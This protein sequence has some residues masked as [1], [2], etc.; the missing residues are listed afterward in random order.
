MTP[1]EQDRS[2]R[3]IGRSDPGG[4]RASDIEQRRGA[5]TG[6]MTRVRNDR[7]NGP[8]SHWPD[9]LRWR[10]GPMAHDR[11]KYTDPTAR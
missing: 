10:N 1:G 7:P 4:N 2:S 5:E 8:T 11:C 3:P 9:T 6:M